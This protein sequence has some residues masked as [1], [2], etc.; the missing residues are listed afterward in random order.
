M[1]VL[2]LVLNQTAAREWSKQV[3]S[4][5]VPLLVRRSA[6]HQEGPSRSCS[7]TR[8]AGLRVA[9]AT[10]DPRFHG[11]ARQLT[12]GAASLA[13]IN[14]T[15]ALFLLVMLSEHVH[16]LRSMSQYRRYTRTEKAVDSPLLL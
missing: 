8:S 6:Q 11:A 10:Q 4:A 3:E 9:S 12:M 16:T 13:Y 5:V 14:N 15:P 7:A 1:G 2:S